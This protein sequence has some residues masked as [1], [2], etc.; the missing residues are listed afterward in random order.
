MNCITIIRRIKYFIKRIPRK[1]G[2]KFGKFNFLNDV[3]HDVHNIVW[4]INLKESDNGTFGEIGTFND[5]DN[6]IIEL[7]IVK[8]RSFF[9]RYRAYPCNWKLFE[10]LFRIII[11]F[12]KY[13]FEIRDKNKTPYL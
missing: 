10:N 1:V 13:I 11:K 4:N 5:I 3:I 12:E 2:R 6:L 9:R 8:L 7:K